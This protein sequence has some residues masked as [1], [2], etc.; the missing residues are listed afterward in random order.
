MNKLEVHQLAREVG[1]ERAALAR[2][3]NADPPL[4]ATDKQDRVITDAGRALLG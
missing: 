2:M 1:L 3:Y 4:L